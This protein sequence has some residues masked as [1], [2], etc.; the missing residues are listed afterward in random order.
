MYGEE[1]I[2]IQPRT[3]KISLHFNK[4]MRAFLPP[5]TYFLPTPPLCKPAHIIYRRPKKICLQK[6]YKF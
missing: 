5:E 2:Q 3:C 1:S 6:K 4:S